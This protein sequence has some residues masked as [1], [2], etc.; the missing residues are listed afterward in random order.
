[1]LKT[2][3][4]SR[5]TLAVWM[6]LGAPAAWAQQ[7]VTPPDAAASAAPSTA[8]SET[9][10][11][12]GNGR[13]QQLQSV[14]I[15]LQIVPAEQI[16]KL[17]AANLADMNGYIPG[18]QI[19]A[20][21]PTQP[22]FSLRGIG[23]GDFGIGTDAPVGVYV[24]GVYT[25]KT[26]G[27][28]LNFNDVKRIEVLKGP[29][30][31]LFG[32]NSAGGAISVVSNEPTG[33][34]SASGLLRLGSHNTRHLEAV[35]NQP[36]GETLAL[37]ISGTGQFSHGWQRDAA[38]GQAERGEHAW[39]TRMALA[40]SPSDAT[41]VLLSWEHEDLDQR[42]VPAIGLLATPAYGAD[43]ASYRDP[44]Q[45][46]LQNDVPD[47]REARR[48]NGATLRIEHAL[49]WADF[50]SITAYRHFNAVNRTDNDGTNQLTSYLSTGNVEA[51]TTWQQEFKLAGRNKTVD[52]LAGASFF[53]ERAQQTSEVRSV[54]TALDTLFGNVA[55]IAPFATLNEL[56]QAVG[57]PGVDL[58]GQPWQEN[59]FN[60]GA[61]QALALY[62]D[63]IWHLGPATNLTTGLRFTRDRKRFSWYSPTRTAQG[64]DTQLGALNAADFF[65]TLVGAGVLSQNDADQLAGLVST[66]QLVQGQGASTQALQVQKSWRNVSPRVVLDHRVAADTM[67]Y[68]SVTRGYQAGGFN[69]LQVNG[70]Y[71]PET[72]TSFELGVKGSRRE[73]GL[74]YS[75]AL[76][77]YR[78]DNLQSLTLVPS[79]N[80][81]GVPAYLVTLSDQRATG[82][83]I[84]AR[85]QAT[86][87]WRLYSAAEAIDQTYKRRTASDGSDLS[88]QPVGTPRLTATLGTDYQWP[89]AGGTATATLQGAYVGAT[90]CNAE[91]L[92][93]G[94]CLQTPS[95][96]VG[97]ART[98]VDARF[99]W[100]SA[101]GSAGNWGV[102][103]V[104]N[105]LMNRRYVTSVNYV[106]AGLGS[107]YAMITP[108]RFIG[109]ELRAS[110]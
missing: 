47:N 45:A 33:S 84:E 89:L 60:S 81:A 74:S 92:A 25:G 65:P 14:P 52:W 86:R 101:P 46:P 12:T 70:D 72:V 78:F 22:L 110:L 9:V 24:D 43:P 6:A 75:A 16:R 23:T 80:Q 18:L 98:R 10:T 91:S 40:W 29:Q 51:N 64:L 73:A 34:F 48:F 17:G 68:G 105:N 11:V 7:A 44:R 106:A 59:M 107:P 94:S 61:Y 93:Q 55:G 97:G 2:P 39:G 54:T 87:Q 108:P 21:Q 3:I 67:V 103:L 50:S 53:R 8:A 26:G 96:R 27:A 13:V 90:R 36:L 66:N 38:S 32:R 19:V 109:I 49:P 56:A 31:T 83:D 82:L 42:A 100:E 76:F 1:M 15:A 104:L 88:G 99:G 20:D 57:V 37:R 28:L 85:W 95:F 63:T 35:V 69:A 41:R 71:A 62:G 30:G 4:R 5:L 79:A 58:L 77:H 102:A